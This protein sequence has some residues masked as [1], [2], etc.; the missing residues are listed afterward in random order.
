MLGLELLRALI[1]RASIQRSGRA[2]DKALAKAEGAE[3]SPE[4]RG[5]LHLAGGRNKRIDTAFYL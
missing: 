3:G 5:D 2:A 1:V 4:I